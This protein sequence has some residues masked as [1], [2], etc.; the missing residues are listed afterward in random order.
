MQ[1][2]TSWRQNTW[3][4]SFRPA[5]MCT[6]AIPAARLPLSA[7]SGHHP[8]HPT[9]VHAF[10]D[11]QAL[12][13]VGSQWA[14]NKKSLGCR[15]WLPAT[16]NLVLVPDCDFSTLASSV[17]VQD[18]WMILNGCHL[19]SAVF[20][21]TIQAPWRLLLQPLVKA[22]QFVQVL[23]LA[24]TI[25]ATE[26]A[27]SG[28]DLFDAILCFSDLKPNFFFFFRQISDLLRWTLGGGGHLEITPLP[29]KNGALD[30]FWG[31]GFQLWLCQGVHVRIPMSWEA[32]FAWTPLE[33][34]L[35]YQLIWF[36]NGKL[37]DWNTLWQNL[38]ME[39]T[40]W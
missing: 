11:Q 14:D 26:V 39:A 35:G 8:C 38:T 27:Y 19:K 40:A 10:L 5:N 3:K 31:F 12:C 24:S 9:C 20:S 37:G 34:G 1:Q 33:I 29:T 16:N 15:A 28:L 4:K 23:G 13:G 6:L 32:H 21:R 7:L 25:R 2:T 36:P 22:T 30:N 18:N 17:R